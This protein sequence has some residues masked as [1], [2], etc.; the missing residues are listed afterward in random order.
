MADKLLLT[1]SSGKRLD[2]LT[3]SKSDIDL[4]DIVHALCL[5]CRFGGH[6]KH[7]Y[8]VAEHS[9]LTAVLCRLEG[10]PLETQFAALH[11]DDQEA[12]LCDLPTPIK[13][14]LK[15]YREIEAKLAKKIGSHFRLRNSAQIKSKVQWAD[16]WM[17][18]FEKDILLPRCEWPVFEKTL[19]TKPETVSSF[20]QLQNKAE[21]L[22][23]PDEMPT[24]HGKGTRRPVEVMGNGVI[25]RVNFMLAYGSFSHPIPYFAYDAY[26]ILHNKLMEEIKETN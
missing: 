4:N 24:V 6:C 8:S 10:L 23:Y 5:I 20:V 26:L 1:T 17:C 25:K 21:E 14:E 13:R 12:Y 9:V 15:K 19:G 7:F 3:L 22:I 18:W 2:I 11:H 16:R